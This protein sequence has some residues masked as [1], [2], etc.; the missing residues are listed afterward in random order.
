M[1]NTLATTLGDEA[2]AEAAAL[3]LP[4]VSP[5]SS[6]E[7]GYID[8][9]D[10]NSNS[11][12][13]EKMFR[14]KFV[15]SIYERP[16]RPI[17]GRLL[18]GRRW[19]SSEER[20]VVMEKLDVQPEDNAL[21]V[22]CGPGNYTRP[23][24]K[25]A[26]RGIAIGIDMS[27]TMVASGARQGGGSNLAYVRGDAEKLPFESGRFDVACCINAIHMLRSPMAA[28]DEMMRVLAPGGRLLIAALCAKGNVPFTVG[29][30]TLFGRDA[31]TTPLREN[32]FVQIEQQ[33]NQ[34]AQIV[35]ARRP[36]E[37]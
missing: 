15:V 25:A 14:S 24:A 18:F 21:D 12:I 16:W 4:Q 28:L 20:R 9:L 10:P 1:S 8:L 34:R 29:A 22:C 35:S 7:S 17:A 27:E 13:G 23:L 36:V 19:K 32:G 37:G 11:R 5:R 26:H 33:I 3:F 6:N 31:F 30:Y 2:R